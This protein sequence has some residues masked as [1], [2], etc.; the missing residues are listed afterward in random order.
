MMLATIIGFIFKY[1][2]DKILIF[3][4]KT[5]YLSEK[6]FFQILFYGLFAIIT[7]FI[8]WIAEISFKYFI[9]FQISEYIGAL[10][11]LSIGYTIKFLLDRKYVF[12]KNQN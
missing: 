4:D 10:L 3:K 2:V 6:H 11:G 9:N 7:T 5:A 12:D 1:L 8:F